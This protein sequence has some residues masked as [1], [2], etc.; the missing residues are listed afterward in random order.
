MSYVDG[1]ATITLNQAS[2]GLLVA[3]DDY[4][5]ELGQEPYAWSLCISGAGLVYDHIT[6][7]SGGTLTNGRQVKLTDTTVSNGGLV[8]LL[9]NCGLSNVT[10]ESGGVASH[11]QNYTSVN[12]V[13][14]Y[15]GGTLYLGNGHLFGTDN[16]F[17]KGTLKG[18]IQ[19][20]EDTDAYGKSYL[21]QTGGAFYYYRCAFGSFVNDGGYTYVYSDTVISN[22]SALKAKNGFALQNAYLYNAQITDGYIWVQANGARISLGGAETNIRK[23]QFYHINCANTTNQDTDLYAENGVLY[24]VKIYN[25]ARRLCNLTILEGLTVSS[26]I[27][28]SGGLLTIGSGGIAAGAVTVSANGAL[29][30]KDDAVWGD[31]E[32]HLIGGAMIGGSTLSVAKEKLYLKQDVSTQTY[33]QDGVVHDLTLKTSSAGMIHALHL[34]SGVTALNP[35]V[36]SGGTLYVSSGASAIKPTMYTTGYVYVYSGGAIS[37]AVL[38]GRNASSAGILSM[39]S[40]AVI[41]GAIVVS[42]YG[43]IVGGDF[44]QNDA[45]LNIRSYGSIGGAKLNVPKEKLFF[46][47]V[48]TGAYVENGVLHDLTLNFGLGVVS[49]L[50]FANFTVNSGATLR[51]S[52]GTKLT[53]TVM[54]GGICY[55][56]GTKN[57]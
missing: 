13:R 46:N 45:T 55:I 40:E 4:Q 26:P 56:Y 25:S 49:G 18:N 6:V 35:V 11:V 54:N 33:I 42:Q 51:V 8:R 50:K 3:K 1:H 19:A 9:S 27:I 23:G 24:G 7:V 16:Y 39:N 37:G 12:Q 29:V 2:G 28:S 36:S 5:P 10:I 17:E 44:A 32:L 21:K 41:S 53:D 22:G 47:G 38:S 34:L 48:S 52:R 31:A 43:M 20:L 14:V 57:Y 15:S 30:V